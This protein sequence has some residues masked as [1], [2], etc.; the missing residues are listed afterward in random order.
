MSLEH[1]NE[2]TLD[3]QPDETHGVTEEQ[4]E[5]DDSEFEGLG[6][7]EKIDWTKLKT[8]FR[9]RPKTVDEEGKLTEEDIYNIMRENKT[10]PYLAA[11]LASMSLTVS[12]PS[13]S[14]MIKIQIIFIIPGFRQTQEWKL[15]LETIH[16]RW[17]YTQQ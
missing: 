8:I 5:E 3:Q 15:C 1:E 4:Q 6:L 12:I 11:M 17:Q 13:K 7:K 14:L 9:Y 10:N 16:H 2:E